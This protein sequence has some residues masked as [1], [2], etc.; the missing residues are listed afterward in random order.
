MKS[1]LARLLFLI[2]FVILILP[3]SIKA[4]ITLEQVWRD[5]YFAPKS[6]NLGRSMNDGLHFS[7]VE[8]DKKLNVYSYETGELVRE[9][10]STE[11]LLESETGKPLS[12]NSYHFSSDEN[13]L[14]VG[15]NRQS[16]YRRS[17]S[18]EYYIYDIVN[19]NLVALSEGTR[20]T[21]PEFSPNGKMVAFVRDDNIFVKVIETGNEFAVTTDGE[22]NKIINGTTDW[23]YEEEFAFTKGFHWSPDGS[24]IAFLRFDERH[25]REFTFVIYGELYPELYTYKYPK[26]GEDNSLVSLHIYDL[27]TQETIMVDTGTDPE[28]YIPR[29]MWTNDPKKLA[30]VIMNRP[31][32]E[33]NILIADANSGQSSTSYHETNRYFIEITDDLTFLDDNKHFIISSTKSGYNHLYLYQIDGKLVSSITQGSWDVASFYGIDQKAGLVYFS[34]TEQSP[35]QR[36]LYSIRIDG[37]EKQL[38]TPKPGTN[39]PSFSKG[40]KFFINNHS[41]ANTPPVISIHRSDGSLIKVLEDNQELSN[42]VAEHGFVDREFFQIETEPGVVLNAWRM[43]PADFDP[44]KQYP[45]LMYVYGGPGS[46]TVLDRWDAGNGPWYQMLAQ[47]GFIIVSVDNRGTGGRGEEFMKMTYLQLGK[48]ETID[49]V[50]A[51]R[52][53]ASL[54]YVNAD[55]ITIFGWSYGGYI[56]ALC[57]AW[58]ADVFAGAVSVA[59]VTSWRYY[60]TIYTERYMRTPQEN[61]NGYDDNSP[62]N[63]VDKIKGK[64]LLVHGS[65]DDNVHYQNTMEMARALVDANIPFELAIYPNHNHGIRGGNAR[66]HLFEHITRFLNLNWGNN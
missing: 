14:L 26:A 38:L 10:F 19:Q 32:N 34:S 31:Q 22:A 3:F 7:I 41:T 28:R 42:K 29:F 9:V 63:H 36:H 23:V 65:A 62:I 24:K 57:L 8:Q 47:M 15:V 55:A 53:L 2:P 40:F 6:I 52:Y 44:N 54:P 66:L 51:A 45:V 46:Q 27:E 50:N 39:S 1:I 58:G 35:M 48:Y 16:I 56:S 11:G 13:F 12:I 30:V 43:F 59:P 49:Q 61:P 37:T 21:L 33:L 18:A 20:Q 4:Q 17:Y 60:N 64:L 5:R 25:V